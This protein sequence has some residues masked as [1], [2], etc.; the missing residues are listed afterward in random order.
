MRWLFTVLKS[1]T[2]LAIFGLLLVTA[3]VIVLGA[4]FEWDWM[5]RTL[6]ILMVLIIALVVTLMRTMRANRSADQ[7]ERSIK[8]QAEQQ[9][10]KQAALASTPTAM[11]DLRDRAI[12]QT[13]I[14]YNAQA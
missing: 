2:F 5:I 4:F 8:V 13:R 3:L 6:A 10:A 1:R 14:W 7:I 9:L 11:Q 12:P